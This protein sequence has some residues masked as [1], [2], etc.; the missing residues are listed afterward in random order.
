M[1]SRCQGY[2]N[3]QNREKS[4]LVYKET[5]TWKIVHMIKIHGLVKYYEK[6]K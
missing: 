3:G 6:K 1:C 4:F 5:D 2:S